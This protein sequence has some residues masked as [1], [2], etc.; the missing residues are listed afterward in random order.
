MFVIYALLPVVIMTQSTM[1]I[2][3]YELLQSP[4][5]SWCICINFEWL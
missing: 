3:F 2:S 5:E 1:D 4:T